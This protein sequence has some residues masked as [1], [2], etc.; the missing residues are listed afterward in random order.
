MKNKFLLIPALFLFSSSLSSC[1]KSNQKI[2]IKRD[3]SLTAAVELT[4]DE[5]ITKVENEDSF[6]FYVSS[7]SCSSCQRFKEVIN[8]YILDTHA[9]L[10]S[11]NTKEADYCSKY[12]TYK[13]TPT[14]FVFSEG[15]QV[16]KT[17]YDSGNLNTIETFKKYIDKYSYLSPVLRIT[18]EKLDEMINEKKSF[19][20]KYTWD[21]CGD[22]KA[23]DRDRKSTRLNSSH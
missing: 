15:K 11:I 20:I 8:K 2:E 16:A 13:I 10:Y 12:F 6:I 22:C 23:A 19:V 17:D 9:I 1:N 14:L 4:K 7:S 18:M 5:F 3:E 21:K